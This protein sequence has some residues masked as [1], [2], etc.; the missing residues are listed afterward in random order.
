MP[1]EQNSQSPPTVAEQVRAAVL[2][3][4]PVC[5]PNSY[6]G[7]RQTY[8][9]YSMF[10]RPADFGDDGPLAMI[11]EVSVHLYLPLS[12]N[13]EETLTALQGALGALGTYPTVEDASDLEGQH[14]VLELQIPAG[15]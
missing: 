1:Q 3:I 13:P 11:Y 8:C 7:K 6:R 5:E 4:V 2:P 15:V 10:R 12:I 9:L 14:Y